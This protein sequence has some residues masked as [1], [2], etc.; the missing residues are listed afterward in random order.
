MK[1][2]LKDIS[3]SDAHKLF[4][5]SDSRIQVDFTDDRH[6]A[7]QMSSP[8]SKECVAAALIKLAKLILTDFLLGGGQ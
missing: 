4:G 6:F 1:P 3:F 8:L 2:T 7:V 5:D